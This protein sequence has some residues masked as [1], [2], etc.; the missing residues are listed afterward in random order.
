MEEQ[1]SRSFLVNSMYL[2]VLLIAGFCNPEIDVSFVVSKSETLPA[3]QNLLGILAVTVKLKESSRCVVL[4]V[5]WH[6]LC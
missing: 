4:P 2:G 6:P 3:E 1:R 5:R